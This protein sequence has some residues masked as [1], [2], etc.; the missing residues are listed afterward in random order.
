MALET[1][2]TNWQFFL[3]LYK[4]NS[5]FS[6]FHSEP[7]F[8]S[9]AEYLVFEEKFLFSFRILSLSLKMNK[10]ILKGEPVNSAQATGLALQNFKIDWSKL[11]EIDIQLVVRPV[12]ATLKNQT[13]LPL[14]VF[15]LLF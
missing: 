2:L 3:T 5:G 15:V 10:S 11:R 6:I 7:E 1:V 14:F 4:K 13:N 8:L 12:I 9:L